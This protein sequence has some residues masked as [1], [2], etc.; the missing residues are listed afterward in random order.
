MTPEEYLNGKPMCKA[1]G[2]QEPMVT[3]RK[4][5]GKHKYERVVHTLCVDCYEKG[6]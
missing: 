6:Q 1:C 4:I 3:R 2:N 5:K